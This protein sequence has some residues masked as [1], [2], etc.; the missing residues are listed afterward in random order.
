M[1]ESKQSESKRDYVSY[2]QKKRIN[3]CMY[4]IMN[5]EVKL[6][7]AAYTDAYT[8]R[9]KINTPSLQC[10]IMVGTSN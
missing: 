1:S 9:R 6:I 4:T 7:C 3:L 2:R 10:L 5:G 8:A